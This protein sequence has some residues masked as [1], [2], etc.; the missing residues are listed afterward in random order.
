M[1]SVIYRKVYNDEQLTIEELHKVVVHKFT[2]GDVEDPDLYAGEPLYRWQ[3]S[4]AGKFVMEHATETP[5][6]ERTIDHMHFGYQYAIVA[7]LEKKKLSEFYLRFD[8]SK[9]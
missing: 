9:V 3:Q 4:E 7:T 5:K 8:I 1:A 6:W 2:V